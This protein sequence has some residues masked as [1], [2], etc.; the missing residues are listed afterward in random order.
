M[1]NGKGMIKFDVNKRLGRFKP[2]GAGI[3]KK[4]VPKIVNLPMK[5]C[6]L[7]SSKIC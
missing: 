4:W 6:C 2:G 7:M 3:N 1:R 5:D